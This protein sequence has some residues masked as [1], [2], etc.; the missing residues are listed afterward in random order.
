MPRKRART[1][2]LKVVPI[3]NAHGVRLPKAILDKYAV[4]NTLVAEEQPDGLLLRGTRR[5]RH[6]WDEAFKRMAREG[7]DW[8]D[9]DA[10]AA[11]GLDWDTVESPPLTDAQL[12]RM[13][14]AKKVVP[15]IV[16][17][18]RRKRQSANR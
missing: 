11:D 9:L 12:R 1:I 6:G 16:A 5:V 8:S 13:K 7:E 14:P 10:A 2:K 15:S 17:A 4:R 3:S 18:Y